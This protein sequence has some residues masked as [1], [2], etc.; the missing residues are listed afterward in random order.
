MAFSQSSFDI[1]LNGSVLM[2]M[3]KDFKG[4]FQSSAIDLNSYIG[5][6]EGQLDWALGGN[7][8]ASSS[9]L[10]F[11][12]ASTLQAM[13]RTSSGF[14]VL[15]SINLDD[16]ITNIDGHLMFKRDRRG[17]F[18]TTSRD[19][20]LFDTILEA[21]CQAED[22]SYRPSSVDLNQYIGN[23]DG[24]LEWGFAGFADSSQH[25]SLSDSSYLLAT[26]Q[27]SQGAYILSAV[28]LDERLVNVN[29]QLQIEK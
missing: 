15:A 18:S 17:G 2:A 23:I 12:G 26:C 29:G 16:C 14:E 25:I 10:Q 24:C 9:N 5:N 4:V 6:H 21:H 1:V 20:F 13:C 19:I 7:F 22:G 8:A 28:N 3:C 11:N 27:T